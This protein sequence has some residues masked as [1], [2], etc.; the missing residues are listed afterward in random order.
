MGGR[1]PEIELLGPIQQLLDQFKSA[2][3]LSRYLNTKQS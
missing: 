1:D 3:V 2:K